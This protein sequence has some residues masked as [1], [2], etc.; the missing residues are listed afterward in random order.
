MKFL[1]ALVLLAA[2][3]A[4][5]C[6]N[7]RSAEPGEVVVVPLS[8]EISNAQTAFLRRTLKQAESAGASAYV[9]EMDTP[10]G[11]LQAAVDIL[12]LLLKARIPTYT[13]VN[14]NAGSAGAL[15][16]L[17][18][19]HIYMAPVSAIGAAAPVSSEGADIP[20]T[21]N[22][23]V[24][25][26]FSGYFRS[27]AQ[28]KGRNPALAQAFIDKDTEF[29][30][31]GDI[32][33]A[34]GSLLTLSAQ[35]AVRKFDG[36]PLLADGLADSIEQLKAGAKLAGPTERLEPSG[37][38]RI[39]QWVT[40]LAPLFLVGGIA[41]AY[42]EFKAP[43]FGVAGF[44][45]IACFAIFFLGHYIA[46][47]TGLEVIVVFAL[48]LGLVLVELLFFPG[49]T[50]VAALGVA[51]ML[52]SALFAMVDYFP[53]DPIIPSPEQL[54]RP[55]LNLAVA[56]ALSAVAIGLLARYFPSLPF[57]RRLLLPAASATG[58]SLAAST[59]I[60]PGVHPGMVG[61]ARS[62]LRPAGKAEIG[63][64]F[65]DVVTEGEFLDAGTPVRV[66]MVEGSRVVV[67]ASA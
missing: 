45:S 5:R 3:L 18:T 38:E 33:S 48:G 7:V 40:L 49:V 14:T 58:P 37:F 4:G 24:I 22:A 51:L 47:L 52:G 44:V 62:I 56:L 54:M 60:R 1:P 35:E 8:G 50:V 17:G 28:A 19:D 13:W 34:K 20:Q 41:A 16:A 6:E 65:V 11:E 10:G 9:I 31:G 30:I 46:G 39:A 59:P 63:G 42:L 53:G 26:Y 61:V 55:A 67:S 66:T 57:F 21:M 43:G 36:K 25:S 27:A 12:Q 64:V 15:I 32:I 29:K 23:K 2:L